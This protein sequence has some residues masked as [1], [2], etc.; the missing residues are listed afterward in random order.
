MYCKS[1]LKPL[2][3]ETKLSKNKVALRRCKPAINL[4]HGGSLAYLEYRVLWNGILLRRYF[5]TSS[6]KI[7]I[8][9]GTTLETLGRN[10]KDSGSRITIKRGLFTHLQFFHDWTFLTFDQTF[11]SLSSSLLHFYKWCW[12][13]FSQFGGFWRLIQ[14]QDDGS[15]ITVCKT[16]YVIS[17]SFNVIVPFWRP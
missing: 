13:N 2:Q 12:L 14:I 1:H 8:N 6:F 3:L 11:L 4:E 7:T 9:K 15:K 10:L 16:N 5:L 17:T